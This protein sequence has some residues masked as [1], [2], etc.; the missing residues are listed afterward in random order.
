MTRGVS[1][2]MTADFSVR[3]LLTAT[4]VL[5]LVALMACVPSPTSAANA[6]E[7]VIV[8][9]GTV[10]MS[11]AE[12]VALSVRRN[13][14]I[15]LAYLDRVLEKYSYITNTSFVFRPNVSMS[16]AATR[17]GNDTKD[18]GDSSAHQDSMTSST[19]LEQRLPTGAQ[20]GVQW[21]PWSRSLSHRSSNETTSDSNSK[22]SNWGIN[23]SQPLLK[24]GGSRVATLEV[25]RTRI[26]EHI[27][28][29]R[30]KQ[31][32][33]DTVTGVIK[34][35][36]A[37][38]KAR[39]DVD[40][41]RTSLER[42]V[43]LLETNKLL[44]QLGR[45]AA[46]DIIQSEADVANKELSLEVALNTVDR[47]RLELLRQLD[48]S[49]FLQIVPD[50]EIECPPFTFD[51]T[52]VLTL[53]RENQPNY[54]TTKY[55][56]DLAELTLV[57]ARDNMKWDLSLTGNVGANRI[58]G[59]PSLD[60]RSREWGL[61]MSLNVPV[62]GTSRRD[63]RSGMMSAETDVKKANINLRKFSDNL[64][65]ECLDTVRQ[66]RT[67][68]KQIEL[69]TKARQ[70]SEQKLAVEQEKLRAGRSS[71]FQIVTYQDDLRNAKISE[72]SAK[73]AY[74]NALSDLDIFMGTM[75]GTWGID[76]NDNAPVEGPRSASEPTEIRVVDPASLTAALPANSTTMPV[77]IADSGLATETASGAV[78]VIDEAMLP[79]GDI[80]PNAPAID[81]ISKEPGTPASETGDIR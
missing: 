20:I 65:L 80:D 78:P 55:G 27:N 5:L 56:V 32:V 54:L 33:M 73:I 66:I 6:T 36:R 7:T 17:S 11:L 62:Y 3:G 67:L 45:M 37:L 26:Q 35:Y 24:G 31:T 13:T 19:R 15:R 23:L 9:S 44:I 43:T 74:L 53:A 29:L 59:Q 46:Q 50:E 79:Q 14:T 34:A 28:V 41:N 61:G 58:T 70:L 71:N 81:G 47:A 48:L 49:K 57:R 38:V 77:S 30:L 18:A 42:A 68:Q 4:T 64:E 72:L 75:T 2:T 16:T 40:I 21:Q 52:R 51:E 63:L 25:R 39:W 22:S 8:A 69:A 60:S 76:L 10:R 12:C 1:K